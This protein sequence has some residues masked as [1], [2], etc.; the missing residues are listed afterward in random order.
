MVLRADRPGAG[1]GHRG[2]A[3]RL[4]RWRAAAQLAAIEGTR[5]AGRLAR[6][7]GPPLTEFAV[8]AAL[9]VSSGLAAQNTAGTAGLNG[10]FGGS[11]QDS[12]VV[13]W[14][15]AGQVGVWRLA[16]AAMLLLGARRLAEVCYEG[17]AR[18]SGNI[19][20]RPARRLVGQV[21]TLPAGERV[22]VIA[23]T[24]VFFGPRLTFD[25][26]LAWGVVAAGYVL[27]AQLA[28]AAKLARAGG[29][30]AAYREDARSGVPAGAA[31]CGASCRRCRRCWWACW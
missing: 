27:A 18:A 9:A 5:P 13:G 14:G 11:L 12:Q 17:L 4:R 6:R 15:G 22:A 1:P 25:V 7:G 30:L 10:I 24:A 28:G 3:R 8:Y 19:S 26:L 2:A 31:W 20:A 23:V 16:V 21:I 29:E